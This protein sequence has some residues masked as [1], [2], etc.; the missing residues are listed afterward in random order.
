[1]NKSKLTNIIFNALEP[2]L[3]ASAHCDIPCG[4]YNPIAAE[5]A[6]ETVTKMM[7][8]IADLADTSSKESLNSIAR[9]IDIKEKNAEIV[10]HEIRIIWGDYFKPP[11]LEK[12]PD[13]HEKTW[14]I[15]KTAS[16]CRVGINIDD[17][18]KLQSQVS[19]FDK[20]FWDSK[21]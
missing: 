7:N 11:H 9:Y 18:T 4:I 17:A 13:L 20:I 2:K 12:Y 21:K 6:A 5:I 19:D 15:M 8:L 3:T 10:K 1:M 16:S 14:N